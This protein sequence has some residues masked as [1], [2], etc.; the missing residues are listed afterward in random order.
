MIFEQ[1]RQEIKDAH[2]RDYIHRWQVLELR[3]KATPS[4][5]NHYDPTTF[6]HHLERNVRP[7]SGGSGHPGIF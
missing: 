1:M 2:L 5:P 4:G 3:I 6:C 7:L